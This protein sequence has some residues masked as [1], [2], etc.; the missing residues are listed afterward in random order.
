MLS[1]SNH[2]AKPMDRILVID[3]LPLISV[4]FQDLFRSI[5]PSVSVVYCENVYTALSAK[6]YAGAV[7]DLVIVGSVPDGRPEQAIRELKA[8]FNQPSI[9]LYS[10]VYDPGIIEKME[11]SGIEAYVHRY[12]PIGEILEAYRR[13][14]A[15]TRF[16]S[17]IFRTLYDDY[18]FD[19]RN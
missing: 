6:A 17:S 2:H 4:A 9:L 13:L 19:V 3:E 1:V 15:G 18:R 5:N 14:S 7:F 12:E 11:G 16:V 10:A 8:R